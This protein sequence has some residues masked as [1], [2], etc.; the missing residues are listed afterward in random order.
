MIRGIGVDIVDLARF[1]RQVLRTPGLIPRLFT[2]AERAL[3]VHSLAARFA[4]KEA[5]IKALGD[6]TGVSWQEMGVITDTHGNPA[7]AL[8]GAAQAAVTARGVTSVHL[9]MTHDA[10]VACAFVVIEGDA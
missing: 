6:S 3:P 7:F 9:T 2:E 4:A 8:H 1:E 5:L 10:G